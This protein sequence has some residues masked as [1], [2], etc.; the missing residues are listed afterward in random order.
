MTTQTFDVY[1]TE[2]GSVSKYIH[3]DGSE[4]AIKLVKSVQSV[5]NPITKQIDTHY[6]DRNKYSIFISS[7]VGC[8]MKCKFCHLTLKKAKHT[9]IDHAPLLANL[10]EAI[11][12]AAAFN[13]D[14]K[15][16]FVKLSWMGMGDAINKPD[17]VYQVTLKLLDWIFENGYAAGLDGVDL[18]TVMPKLTDHVWIPTFHLLD[19]ELRKY[20]INPVYSMDNSQYTNGFYSHKNYF[21]LFFSL[22][23]A[24]QEQRD[25]VIPKAMPIKEASNLL[26]NYAAGGQYTVILHHLLVHDLNDSEDELA[27][28]V[29]LINCDFT[30]NELRIL[31]YNF[32]AKSDYKES[33]RFVKQIRELA[34][35]IKFVK[36]QVSPGTEVSAACGQFIVKKFVSVQGNKLK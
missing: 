36:V 21:R 13:P 30:D 17:M 33:E 35:K 27:A 26:K 8:Y 25:I 12:D 28:L 20:D 31:R 29:N 9:K 18:S 6:T 24:I 32:C 7:S 14:L 2:D 22:G 3:E 1:R 15:T 10:K 11:M 4:T 5:V 19:R 34:D 16:R 23:S